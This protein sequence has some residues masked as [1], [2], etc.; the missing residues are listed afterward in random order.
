MTSLLH[1]YLI[2]YNGN[3][4]YCVLASQMLHI[5]KKCPYQQSEFEILFKYF[6]NFL[7]KDI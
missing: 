5:R 2:V 3:L 6:F 4:L 7:I 1:V